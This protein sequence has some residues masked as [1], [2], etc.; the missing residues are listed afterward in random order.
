MLINTAVNDKPGNSFIVLYFPAHEQ[1]QPLHT[2]YNTVHRETRK[3]L[4]TDLLTLWCRG[5]RMQPTNQRINESMA[6]TVKGLI[7]SGSWSDLL[8]LLI[9]T[10]A[11]TSAIPPATQHC[12]LSPPAQEGTSQQ[13]ESSNAPT[14]KVTYSPCSESAA[15]LKRTQFVNAISFAWICTAI[16]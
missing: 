11:G 4:Q 1:H 8:H 13:L 10:Q 5:I 14:T 3:S 16:S 6:K 9:P 7:N 15:S 2:T 12:Y